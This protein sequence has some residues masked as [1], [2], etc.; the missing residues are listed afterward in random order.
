MR[1]F[2]LTLISG[3]LVYWGSVATTLDRHKIDDQSYSI[4]MFFLLVPGFVLAIIQVWYT[5]KLFEQ[6]TSK[7]V[8][9][10]V[11]IEE[12]KRIEELTRD[13]VLAKWKS[14]GK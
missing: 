9:Q 3:A 4:T 11:D 8:E 5:F 12:P 1:A 14:R 10:S 2:I 6:Q 7:E 13:E